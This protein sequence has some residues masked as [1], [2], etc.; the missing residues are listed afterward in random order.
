VSLGL[1]LG[2][3]GH[4]KEGADGRLKRLQWQSEEGLIKSRLGLKR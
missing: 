3:D 2:S 1:R 4:K